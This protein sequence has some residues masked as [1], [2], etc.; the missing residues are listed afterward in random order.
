MAALRTLLCLVTTAAAAAWLP[1]AAQVTAGAGL[2]A[3]PPRGVWLPGG[4]SYLG[5]NLGR[6]RQALPCGSTSLL[7]DPRERP[8]TEFFMGTMAGDVWGVEIGYLNTGRLARGLGD[9]REGLSL[10]VVG[11]TRMGTS[12]GL[13][14]RIGTTYGRAD[15]LVPGSGGALGASQ[16]F[17]LTYGGG[18]SFDLSPRF[19]AS[20]AWENNDFRFAGS[21][22]EPVRSTSLGLQFRY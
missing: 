9:T 19:S 16:T 15:S 17:G 14:G 20:L 1:V 7:C 12:V 21:G 8:P 22:R 10:N 3:D 5:L 2:A 18:L 13:F 4:R 11:K 6:S